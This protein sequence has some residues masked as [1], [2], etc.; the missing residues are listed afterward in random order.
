MLAVYNVVR[1]EVTIRMSVET[2]PL[3]QY[4]IAREIRHNVKVTLN[5]NC[6]PM[7]YPKVM[8]YDRMRK[9]RGEGGA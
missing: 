5:H 4:A 6:I 3:Q 8:L 7:V 1:T 2:K 9:K